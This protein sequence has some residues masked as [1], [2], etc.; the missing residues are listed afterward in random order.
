VFDRQGFAEFFFREIGDSRNSLNTY[1]SYL[2][3]IDQAVGGLD[4]RIAEDGGDALL[5]WT[6]TA[7][8]EPFASH[9]SQSRS[10]TR[11]YIRFRANNSAADGDLPL[12]DPTPQEVAASVFKY[13]RELQAAVRA[14]IGRLEDG[15]TIDDGGYEFSFESGRADILARDR[16]ACAVVIELKAGPCPKGAIEQVIGYA[17]NWLDEGEPRAPSSACCWRL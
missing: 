8:V 15:L 16:N 11:A 10:I 13:E 9:R 14:Q 17:Q 1:N 12:D 4:E 5:Q 7:D 2:G 3:R 6:A